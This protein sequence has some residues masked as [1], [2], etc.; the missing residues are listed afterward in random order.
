[1]LQNVGVGH[2]S[3]DSYEG[4]APAAVLEEL[5]EQARAL[6]GARVLHVNATAYGGGVSELLRSGVPLLRDLGLRADWKVIGG[7]HRLLPRH[8][9]APQRA[10]GQ[11]ACAEPR[12]ARGLR[13]LH[14]E[15]AD[16]LDGG[17]DF[18]FIHDPQP[19][20]AAAGARQG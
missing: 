14:A 5:R 7:N 3:L 10:A 8:E 19:V 12:R 6:A 20:G 15:N 18:I 13:R 17:Y 9:G 1:M 2:W 16:A 11:P 4:I